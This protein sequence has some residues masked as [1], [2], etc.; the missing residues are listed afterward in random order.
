MPELPEV[1]TVVRTLRPRVVGR[2]VERVRLIRGDV[3]RGDRS[4]AG[5]LS[6]A[7][8]ESI[9]RHGKQL[10]LVGSRGGERRVLVVHLGMSGQLVYA[11]DA[12]ACASLTHVHAMWTLRND[13]GDRAGVLWFRD[14]R[15]FGGLWAVPSEGALRERWGLLGPDGLGVTGT[16][17][18]ERAA[19]SRRAVK[20]ALLDQRV[21]AGVGNIYADEALFRA[22]VRPRRVCARLTGEEWETLAA[23]IRGVLDRAI[24]MRGSTLRDYVSGT[25]EPGRAQLAHEVYG[26]AGEPCVACGGVLRGGVV[27]QRTTVW[28]GACQR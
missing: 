4:A 1:E 7:R 20:G 8:L 17:L 6:G 2:A 24:E 3:V 28:C 22:G 21:V 14:P 12:S 15:R 10:A 26:R 16:E 5:L 11:P 25:G 9:E 27:A 13:G 19:G 18:R 23:S